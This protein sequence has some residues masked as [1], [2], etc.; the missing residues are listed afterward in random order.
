M[1][2]HQRPS[3]ILK[4]PELSPFELKDELIH[5]AK[6][7]SQRKSATHAFLNAG[8]GNPNW[9]ATTPREAFFLLGQFALD[10]S[11]RIWNEPDIGGM[12]HAEGAAVRL[13]E[14]MRRVP[15][16]EGADLLQRGLDYAVTELGFDADNFVHELVDS[17]VGD[18]YPE[19]DRML[20]HAEAVVHRYLMKEMCDDRPPS[21]KYDLFAVEG[22]TA[23]MCYVF[24]SLMENGILERGDTIALGVPIFTPYLEIP[25]L[26]DY[27]LDVVEIHQCE[28]PDGQNAWQYPDSELDKLL[29]PRIK[30]FFI[31]NPSNPASF[32]VS[33][34]SHRYLANL[35]RAARPDLIILTD[36]VYGTF[37]PGFRS[38]AAEMPRNT[39]LVYSYSKHFGC[40]GWRLGVVAL[41]EDNVIDDLLARQ[42][43]R[44]KARLRQRYGTISESPDNIKFI[45]RLVADSRDV[46]LNHTAGLSPPQQ[47]QMTLFSLFAL[48]DWEDR[49]KRRCRAI[50]AERLGALERG[51]GVQVPKSPLRAGYYVELDL[52]AWGR[53]AA[54]EEFLLYV[55]QHSEPLDIVI[56]L[57]RQHGTVLLNGS[58]FDGPAWSAR[59]SLANL[60]ADEYEAIGR[61]LAE[62][63][64]QALERWKRHEAH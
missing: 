27:G 61:D 37:V 63:C 29:D 11:K 26:N 34:H 48:L 42:S 24:R 22:G 13:R 58:G 49:Y 45:D 43:S 7:Y 12:P 21:G 2:I 32:A 25:R 56:T 55:A 59:V 19:P 3:P 10:E 64:R 28:M 31:V 14:F 6:D 17:I 44:Q 9:V 20:H 50:V 15:Q 33:D 51:L 52:E 18:N 46:A 35:I 23:A 62:I 8:R 1:T 40:T 38:F 39:I 5:F 57:A 53:K 54:G 16:T 41:H 60:N 30:A 36:D 47:A 4:R